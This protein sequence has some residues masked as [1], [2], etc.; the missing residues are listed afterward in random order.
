MSEQ[1][2]DMLQ[3]GLAAMTGHDKVKNLVKDLDSKVG[4]EWSRCAGPP[5]PCY[6]PSGDCPDCGGCLAYGF[7][8]QRHVCISCWSV[9][10]EVKDE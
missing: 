4:E 7:E 8:C 2:G 6:A 10:R 9:F 3:I 5:E 1:L